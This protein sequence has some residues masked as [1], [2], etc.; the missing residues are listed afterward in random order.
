MTEGSNEQ[1]PEQLKEY[2]SNTLGSARA[3][4]ARM[5]VGDRFALVLSVDDLRRFVDKALRSKGFDLEVKSGS[6]ERGFGT[7]IVTLK[8]KRVIGSRRRR[9]RGEQPPITLVDMIREFIRNL[10]H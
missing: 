4:L 8:E 10:I 2:S 9:P 6:E 1:E 5:S 3:A 7:H